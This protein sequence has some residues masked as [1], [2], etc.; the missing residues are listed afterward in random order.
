MNRRSE[1]GQSLVELALIIVFVLIILA[2]VVD[3][4]RMMYEYLTMRDAAQEGA[5]YAAIYPNYCDETVNRVMQ[6]LPDENYAVLV[7]VNGIGCISAADSD[8]LDLDNDGIDNGCAG[9][10]VIVELDHDFE[11]T[12]PLISVFTGSTVPMHV[13]I[14]DNIVRPKCN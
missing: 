12:M 5:G 7:W 14:K 2:G 1:K 10:E 4:G 3:L 6:N 9:N 13:E 8:L 11:V